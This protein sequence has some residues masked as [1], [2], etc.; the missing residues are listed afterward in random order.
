MVR[1]A[2]TCIEQS[3]LTALLGISEWTEQDVQAFFS[4]KGLVKKGNGF[5]YPSNVQNEHEDHTQKRFELSQE[6]VENLTKVVQFLEQQ[7][8][9]IDFK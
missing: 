9:D 4:R 5:V 1:K 7:K 8:H 2:F 3:K 6:R